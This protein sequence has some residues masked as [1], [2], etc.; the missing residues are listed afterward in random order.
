MFTEIE[1]L[2]ENNH[3]GAGSEYQLTEALERMV[4]QGAD[5]G[6]FDVGD[7]YDCGQ[8]ETL[9]EANRVLLERSDD[10]VITTSDSTVIISP[11][12]IGEDVTLER[13]V[14]GPCVSV[15]DGATITDSRVSETIVGQQATIDGANLSQSIIGDNAT[16]TGSPDKRNV[17]DSSELKL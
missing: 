4:E 8:P 6:T 2:L 16:I 1:Y 7:W 12:D 15:D 11:V 9:L 10:N 3:R 5:F 17:G 13:S 14:V